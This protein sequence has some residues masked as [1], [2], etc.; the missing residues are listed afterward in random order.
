MDCIFNSTSIHCPFE[1]Y[2]NE[3]NETEYP[4]RLMYT[5]ASMIKIPISL[6]AS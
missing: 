6:S 1:P 3:D 2:L 4:C 5:N